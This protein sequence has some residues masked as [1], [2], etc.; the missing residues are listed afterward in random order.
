MAVDERAR[1][2]LH[3]W[4]EQAAGPER[5]ATLME[6]LP[7][8]GWGDVARQ[9]DLVALRA[10]VEHV[11]VQ[12]ETKIDASANA[13]RAEF[14]QELLHQTRMLFFGMVSSVFTAVTLTYAAVRLG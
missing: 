8:V 2:E 14:R 13:L 9:S 1:H 5:A 3:A 12:L 4:L 7:S 6:L 10:D 11:R